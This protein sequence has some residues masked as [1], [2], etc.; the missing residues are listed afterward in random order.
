MKR[1]NKNKNK[2]K[3]NNIYAA[4]DFQELTRKDGMKKNQRRKNRHSQKRD[5]KYYMDNS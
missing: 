2:N 4:E 5:L 1:K 3:K